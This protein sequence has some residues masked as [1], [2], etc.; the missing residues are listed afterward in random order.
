VLVFD[1]ETNDIPWVSET[2]NL[3]P[4]VSQYPVE[5]D[6]A[7]LDAVDVR[8][9]IAFRKQELLGLDPAEGCPTQALLKAG[10]VSSGAWMESREAVGGGVVNLDRHRRSPW[11]I[12][13]P[14]LSTMP[15]SSQF[16]ASARVC[17]RL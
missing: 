9:C 11:G 12:V 17:I 4:A 1:A 2:N 10:L 3:L 6:G 5:S 13:K 16:L 15:A 7:G 14:H 8:D